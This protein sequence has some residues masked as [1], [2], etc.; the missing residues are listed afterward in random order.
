MS[1]QSANGLD[2][3]F[4]PQSVAI[5]GASAEPGKVGHDLLLNVKNTFSGKIY[6]INLREKEIL[7]LKCFASVLETPAPADLTVIVVPAKAVG[8]V[9]EQCGQKGNKNVI[10]ISA[11]FK[12]IGLAGKELEDSLAAM[13]DKYGINLL[14]PN[15]LG[16][17]STHLPLN[18]SFAEPFT[19]RG[20]IAFISQSG[21]LGTA[22]LD[23]AAAQKIGIGYFVSLGN[24]A[25][26]SEIDLL[27]YF[28][29]QPQIKVIIM[30]LEEIKNSRE[31]IKIAAAITKTKPI[32][33]L[34]AGKTEAGQRAVSSHTGSLAGSARAYSTAFSQSGII[35]ASGID[36]FFNLAKCFS[37]QPLPAGNRVGIVT[38]AGG[39]GILLTDLLPGSGLMIAELAK[40]TKDGLKAI[41]PPAASVQN[42]VDILGDGKADRYGL[43]VKLVLR[44]KNVDSLIVLLTPQKMTEVGLTAET[45]GRLAKDCGKPV[46]L[47]FLGEQKILP[48]YD[49]FEKYSL[50]YY[51]SPAGAAGAL[52]Q[53]LIFAKARNQFKGLAAGENLKVYK[54]RKHIAAIM[55]KPELTEQDCRDLLLPLKFPL[56]RAGLARSEKEALAIAK[57]IGYPVALKVVSP[58]IIHKSD[59]GGVKI[60]LKTPLE[61]KAGLK[62]MKKVLAKNAKGARIEGY[63]VGEMA[64]GLEIILGVKHDPQFG[65]LVM[66][67]A[68]GIYTEIFRDV[69]FRL[70]PFSLAEA[71]KMLAE[72]KIYKLFMGARGQKPLDLEAVA[73]LL[74]KLGN[75]SSQFPEIKEIDFNPVMV[76]AK[77]LGCIVVDL[78]FLK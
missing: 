10:V 5:V 54:S 35:E 49:V 68:G 34:K 52:S 26:I 33:V 66:V 75:F 27:K 73:D 59:V 48:A 56:H 1:Y 76:R 51:D 30:Y 31:F 14:G 65:P 41:L 21:A 58:D 18:A 69:A 72:L 64:K 53:M 20:N 55:A 63:L 32:I 39:P 37:L 61:L 43:A 28:A 45:I 6:P 2:L 3:F 38:N 44:D 57:K 9:L 8:A 25:G 67:G 22:I 23:K 47:C 42:P 46:V 74:V 11:G 7:G 12:E 40:S 17:I 16:Y 24:K 71:K 29:G 19:Q 4:H 15:C 13:A 50:P 60:G 77:G 78:R 70:A 36:E 62:E